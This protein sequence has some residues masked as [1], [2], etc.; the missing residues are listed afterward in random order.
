MF[1]IRMK[2]YIPK[3]T[4]WT[5]ILKAWFYYKENETFVSELSCKFTK[6]V[7]TLTYTVLQVQGIAFFS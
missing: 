6:I 3:W 4:D 2:K 1:F 7:T 5:V